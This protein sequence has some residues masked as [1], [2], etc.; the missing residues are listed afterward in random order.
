MYRLTPTG[1]VR[2]MVDDGS[3][4]LCGVYA[5]WTPIANE[6]DYSVCRRCLARAPQPATEEGA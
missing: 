1:R 6:R 5:A 3:I 2:H 4:A